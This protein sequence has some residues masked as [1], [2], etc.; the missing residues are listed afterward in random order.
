MPLAPL[1]WYIHNRVAGVILF[2]LG[3][4]LMGLG[5]AQAVTTPVSEVET[6]TR[7]LHHT[8]L[9][10]HTHYITVRVKG[11]VIH[12]H[13][14]VL[15]VYVPRTTFRNKIT[16][17][18]VYVPAHVVRIREPSV[19][20]IFGVTGAAVIGVTPP[21]EVVTVQIPVVIPGPVTTVTSVETVTLP[22]QTTVTLPQ[23]TTTVTLPPIS[24]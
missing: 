23:Q 1:R 2:A 8:R 21:A 12:R 7:T 24:G 20:P 14:R 5:V 13:G 18:R 17:K 9:V 4:T 10:T 15:T 3:M 11:H 22:Q 6:Q 16:R 19:P